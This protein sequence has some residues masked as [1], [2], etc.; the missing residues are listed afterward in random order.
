MEFASELQILSSRH[1]LPLTHLLRKLMPFVGTDGLLRVGGRLHNSFLTE[2]EKHPVILPK[3][4][5]VTVLLI[6]KAHIYTLHGGATA[7]QSFS[8]RG[9]WIIHARNVVRRVFRECVI[10]ARH[11][12]RTQEQPMGSLP[13]IRTRPARP[14]YHSGVD[15]TGHF[16]IRA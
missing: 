15:F 10:C 14:F 11:N 7:V 12:A 4:H 6:R 9:F 3:A 5:H 8:F 2:S 13:A 1:E 16:W